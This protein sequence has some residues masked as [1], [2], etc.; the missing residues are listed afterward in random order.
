MIRCLVSRVRRQRVDVDEEREKRRSGKTVEQDGSPLSYE[1]SIAP[2][3]AVSHAVSSL[4]SF[5]V[6]AYP[7]PPA[8]VHS[9][10][11]DFSLEPCYHP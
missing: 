4:F 6:I 8:A 9:L 1:A 3:D 10:A 7:T 11:C 2:N 5:S